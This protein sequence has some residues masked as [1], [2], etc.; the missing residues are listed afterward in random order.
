MTFCVFYEGKKV[1]FLLSLLVEQA[2]EARGE[3]GESEKWII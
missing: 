1:H 2:K 3:R